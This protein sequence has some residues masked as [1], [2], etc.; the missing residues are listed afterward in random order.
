MPGLFPSASTMSAIY[1]KPTVFWISSVSDK[2]HELSDEAKRELA[3][4][5]ASVQKQTGKIEMY[6]AKYYA[7]CTFG[8]LLACVRPLPLLHLL[9]N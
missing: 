7:A 3:A 9:S 2:A 8:G 4:A 5:S 1:S 6:S